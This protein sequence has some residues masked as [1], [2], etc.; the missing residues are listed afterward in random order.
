MKKIFTLLLGFG[1]VSTVGA[2]DF[3][4]GNL[5]VYRVGDGSA[6]LSG[7]ATP[8]FLD[9]YLTTSN[10]SP[11]QSLALATTGSLAIT[12]SGTATSEGMLT[13][14]ANGQYLILTG[15]RANS[16]TAAIAGTTSASTP[17]LV[18]RVSI[19]KSVNVSTAISDRFNTTNIRGAVSTN[20]TDIWVVGGNSGVVYTTFGSAGTTTQVSTTQPTLRC[21]NVFNNQLYSST[22]S[23]AFRISSVGTGTPTTSGQTSV[24]LADIPNTTSAVPS[25]YQF[26]FVDLDPSIPGVDVLYFAD[27]N[28]PSTSTGG[29]NKYA[30]NTTTSTWENKGRITTAS[31]RGLT[32]RVNGSNVEMF[33]TN[34]SNIYSFTDNSGQSGSLSGALTSIATAP[35][36]TAFRGIAFTP[37]NT[38]APIKFGAYNLS[39][40]N[41]TVAINWETKF[42]QNVNEFSVER[43][44]NGTEFSTVGTVA[45]TN[46]VEGSKYS[47]TDVNP[48]DGV[49]YYRIKSTDFDGKTSYTK[50]LIANTKKTAGIKLFGNPV[51]NNIVLSHDKAAKGSVIRIYNSIGSLLQTINV[52]EGA[53]QTSGDVSKLISGSYLAIFEAN[54]VRQN[55]QFVKQ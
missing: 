19:D 12:S 15:Y 36:N 16:G 48:I 33:A 46:K 53:T 13:R 31:I 17:R 25:P 21:I 41:N 38:P 5:V 18:G 42:E 40:V 28:S 37:E 27:D 10:T 34:N 14:S 35:S 54:G 51:R 45:A 29:I 20:G 9:E 43:S 22:A 7:V 39:V 6:T 30:Y 1:L 24:H 23:G 26:F 47:F 49:S 2:Q 44:A 11:V 32:G 4:P 8:I 52:Q 55:V 3:T 50:T